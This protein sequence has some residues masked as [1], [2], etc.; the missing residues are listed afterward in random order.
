M[1]DKYRID[2]HKLIYHPDRVARWM[3]GENIYPLY[4]EM[5]PSGACNHRCTYCAL[6]FMDYK[7]RFLDTEI[8]RQRMPE[9][10]KL[11]LKSVMF[12]GEGEPFLHK[13][14]PEITNFTKAA[15]I[16]TS[17]TTNGALFTPQ[18]ADECLENV[19]WIKVSI[20]GGTKETH[21]K[22]HRTKETDFDKIIA[23]L[24]YAAE[25]AAKK[26]YRCVLG[27]QMVLLPDNAHE[28]ET[29]AK[30]AKRIGMK[31]LV[32]KP[33]S[34][35]PQSKTNLYKDIKYADFMALAEK[36]EYL[37]DEKF[38]VIFRKNTMKSWDSGDK[39]YDKCLA[40]PFWSYID[41][42]GN[43]WGCSMYL[44]DE[45]FLYGNINDRTF[46]EI[47]E[48]EKRKKSLEFVCGGLDASH[49]RLNCR[50]EHINRYLW[51]LTHPSEHVNFI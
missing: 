3:N 20:N 48:G 49:C 19:S 2:S 50:M 23:N 41:A 30:I 18:K 9:M 7:P 1:T 31:Y 33:Y 4:A 45:R 40:L 13:D 15:G 51:E 39:G 10:A 12:A 36:A 42:G 8:L 21:A 14:M 38:S 17:F 24:S 28:I 25:L 47:W 26:N 43:V 34:Q 5:S 22:I 11:G 16:D 6:D 44:E 27:M 32:I 37:N 46:K 35:H 29:L